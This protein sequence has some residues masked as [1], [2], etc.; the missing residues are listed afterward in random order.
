MDVQ[1]EAVSCAVK[2]ALHA[3]VPESGLKTPA[4]KVAEDVLV[5][6]VC[7]GA[8]ANLPEPYFLSLFD[9]MIGLFQS[10]RRLAAY[11]GSGHV[12]EVSTLL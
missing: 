2:E 4:P 7:A 3:A 9:G 6:F 1:A 5:K 10:F 11:E 8:G 12:A